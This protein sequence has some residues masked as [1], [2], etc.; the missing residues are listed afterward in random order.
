VGRFGSIG[1]RAGG[2][3]AAWAVLLAAALSCRGGDDAGAAAGGEASAEDPVAADP[4]DPSALA[5]A[6]GGVR[7]VADTTVALDRGGRAV[8]MRDERRLDRTVA[9]DFRSSARRVHAGS[10]AGDTDERVEAIRVGEAYWTRGAA[11]PWVA[12]DDAVD[13]PE[14]AAAAALAATREMLAL[15]RQCGRIDGDGPGRSVALRVPDCP[16]RPAPD[17]A[18]WTGRVVA[19]AGTLAWT[20]DV[21][22]GADLRAR[23]RLSAGDGTGEAAIAHAFAAVALPDEDAPVPP[24][25][26]Q[27]VP[28]RR[29]RPVR[30]VRTV[31]EGWEDAL[32]PGAP[33]PATGTRR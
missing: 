3:R 13:E 15:V 17:G 33:V 11:G 18:A 19:L 21:L 12:W 8:M 22:V 26:G 23:V 2:R 29:E 16:A 20:G 5:A 7:V 9:G 31:L 14:A 32:G 30:M 27:T 1:R 28:S 10:E 25:A 4:L 6:L 24:E